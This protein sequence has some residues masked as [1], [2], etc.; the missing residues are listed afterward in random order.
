M[1]HCAPKRGKPKPEVYSSSIEESELCPPGRCGG[2]RSFHRCGLDLRYFA[3]SVS[4][5][6]KSPKMTSP[7][8]VRKGR[9]VMPAKYSARL[10]SK[11]DGVVT[12]LAGAQA[13]H[14]NRG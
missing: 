10:F 9:L 8:R 11:L 1:T 12:E 2:R 3:P 13:F 14:R 7:G 6:E 4:E 5:E